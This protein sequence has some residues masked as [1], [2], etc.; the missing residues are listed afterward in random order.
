M[1]SRLLRIS[2]GLAAALSVAASIDAS[3]IQ[4]SDMPANSIS[5]N[6]DN[7]VGGPCNLCGPSVT[8]QY[9]AEG[10]TF[11]NPS[12]PGADTADTNLTAFMPAASIPNIL[13]IYQGG[14][15]G[16]GVALPFEILLSIPVTKIGFDFG[17]SAK[18]YL[19][20]DAYGTN[21]QWLETLTFAGKSAPIGV[22]GFAGIGENTLISK[23]AIS[24]HLYSDPSGTL[25]FAIDNLLVD[26]VSV[27]E[28]ASST[29]LEIGISVVLLAS[30]GH[31]M[32]ARI[33]R[34][35]ARRG[36]ASTGIENG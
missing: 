10:V 24:D 13:Y 23:I 15:I 17:G 8:N 34:S 2:V 3:T 28:P 30:L 27:P 31:H 25:N 16:Q 19:Q 9:A 21:G 11:L 14:L 36:T 6:F 29:L 22:D 12:F 32:I 1:E 33:R 4:F 7:L 5:I 20:L 18:S 35:A 26:G